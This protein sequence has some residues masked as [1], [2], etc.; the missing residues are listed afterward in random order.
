MSGKMSGRV[1]LGDGLSKKPVGYPAIA[2]RTKL[3][4]VTGNEQGRGCELAKEE[5]QGRATT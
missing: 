4:E 1:R 3:I 5:K 2:D